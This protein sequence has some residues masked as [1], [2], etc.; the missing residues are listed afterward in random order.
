M[1]NNV[2]ITKAEEQKAI[3]E[4]KTAPSPTIS[5]AP[6]QPPSTV[7]PQPSTATTPTSPKEPLD[8]LALK[9]KLTKID[10][11]IQ[12]I[13]SKTGKYSA[14]KEFVDQ[15]YKDQILTQDEYIEINGESTVGDAFNREEDMSYVKTVLLQKRDLFV[16]TIAKKIQEIGKYYL[17]D[18]SYGNTYFELTWQD[19]IGISFKYKRNA[20]TFINAGGS[21]EGQISKYNSDTKKY[22]ITYSPSNFKPITSEDDLMLKDFADSQSEKELVTAINRVIERR[23]E[24]NLMSSFEGSW[25]GKDQAKIIL[26][27]KL[28]SLR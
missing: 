12:D 6:V 4:A 15:L 13:Q 19:Q 24:I 18:D 5:K 2:K 10:Q 17:G 11:A 20:Q 21:G 22:E 9:Q 25:I 27:N 16:A 8:I 28:A 23:T 26:N 14:N 3:E 1:L 7:T